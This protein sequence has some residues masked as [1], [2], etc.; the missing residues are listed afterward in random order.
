MKKLLI[1]LTTGIALLFGSYVVP[2]DNMAMANEVYQPAAEGIITR[3]VN[4]R[5]LP[6]TSSTILGTLSK[7]TKVKVLEEVSNGWVKIAAYNRTGYVYSSYIYYSK[8]GQAT[9]TNVQ[10]T[11]NKIIQSGQRYI[12]T[13]YKLGA[14]AGQTRT[15]DCS[16]FTQYI[17]GVNG[18]KLPRSSRE[19]ATVGTSIYSKS[20]LQK[21]DLIFFKTGVRSD[22]KIDHVA[23][24]MGDNKIIH[25]IPNGGVQID[26]YTGFWLKTTVLAKRVI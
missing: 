24:Y 6:S 26:S 13:P 20:Q 25:S 22:G 14:T 21:G 11:A 3:G 19:Q 1:A 5:S 7:G 9:S 4:A 15:F 23:V 8:S 10:N 16:S 12:G 18:V 17:F 2:S